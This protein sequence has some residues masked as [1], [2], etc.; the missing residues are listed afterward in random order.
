MGER[1][2]FGN[3][4]LRSS[5][6]RG[7]ASTDDRD[8]LLVELHWG[9]Q[10]HLVNASNEVQ[11]LGPPQS[12]RFLALLIRSSG[13]PTRHEAALSSAH[14]PACHQPDPRPTSCVC[15]SCQTVLNDGSQDWVLAAWYPLDSHEAQ[16]WLRRVADAS[17][18]TSA[19]E[20][21]FEREESV[22]G[23]SQMDLFT[24]LTQ[25]V[26][27]QMA[28]DHEVRQWIERLA[29]QQAIPDWLIPVLMQAALS[30][31]LEPSAEIPAD[32]RRAWL[33]NLTDTAVDRKT[34]NTGDRDRL[35][36]LIDRSRMTEATATDLGEK[37]GSQ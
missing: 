9:A 30:G 24:W 25:Q 22:N 8:Y 31:K 26:A 11:T 15:E 34:I 19:L 16:A 2:F 14:C 20:Q 13:I 17:D 7:L 33:A 23:V 29:H 27:Q 36:Q 5:R 18:P 37:N 3:C 28:I 21:T 35:L 10:T 12:Q 1:R 32:T 6:V 4:V